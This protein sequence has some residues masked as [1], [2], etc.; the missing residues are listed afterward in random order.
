[1]KA[2][3]YA[4]QEEILYRCRRVGCSFAETPITFEDRRLGESKIN[5]GEVV[6]ALW[7]IFR[8]GFDN[9]CGVPV[10]TQVSKTHQS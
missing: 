8:L 3:G 7:V 6:S 9:L 5:M 1:V 4:F 10:V 2:R